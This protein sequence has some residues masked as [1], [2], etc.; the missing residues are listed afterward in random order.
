MLSINCVQVSAF[1]NKNKEQNGANVFNQY[2]KLPTE[3]DS[4]K[5]VGSKND[6]FE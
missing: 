2:S 3:P 1:V 5:P 4:V 6:F